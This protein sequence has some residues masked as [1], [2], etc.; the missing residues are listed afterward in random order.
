MFD[1]PSEPDRVPVLERRLRDF[2]DRAHAGTW[3]GDFR[4]IVVDLID[5]PVREEWLRRSIMNRP[6]RGGVGEGTLARLLESG[7]GHLER[8]RAAEREMARAAADRARAL[9]EFTRARPASLMDRAEGE[10]GAASAASRAARPSVLSSVSEW[11]VDEIAVAL[12]L[13]A[14]AAEQLLVDSLVLVEKLTSTLALLEAGRIGWDHARVLTELLAP[15]RDEKRAEVE[16]RVLA[17]V[18]G[19]T[20]GQLRVAT[21]RA[22]ARADAKAAAERLVAAMRER[23]VSVFPGED[24][25]AGLYAVLPAPVARACQDAIGRYADACAV[26]GDGRTKAQRMADCLA[27][28]ILRP[29]TNGLPPVQ[30]QLTVVAAVETLLGGDEPGEVDGD[31]VP[32][33]LVRELAYALG[34]LPRPE[35]A[36]DGHHDERWA[37][38]PQAL[39]ELLGVRQ[40]EG[41]ALTHRPR[42]AVVDRLR[43][44][45]LALTDATAIRR[46]EELRPPPDSPGYRPRVE[47][48]RF[49]RLRDRRCRFPGCRVRSRRCDL[50]HTRPWPSGRTSHTNLCCLCEHHHRLSHQAP[51]WALLPAD[52]GGLAWRAPGGEVVTTYPLRFGADDDLPVEVRPERSPLTPDLARDES[53]AEDDEPPF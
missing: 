22:V 40:T 7:A 27:D 24:G 44:T 32:A 12:R 52:D 29:G 3:S 45:L 33:P 18:E 41:I 4:D 46:G 9:A 2:T 35:P 48:D 39:G 36:E 16:A 50:D 26:E 11:A 8:A 38:Q 14:S 53:A 23:Q 1:E 51:G 19:K 43:G 15:V 49:V 20:P 37:G 42:V 17:R 5:V 10:V 6:L 25:M 28:L 30:A 47:L 34:L 13:S 21:R 31:L